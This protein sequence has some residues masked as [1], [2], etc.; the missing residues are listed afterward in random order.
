M[1]LLLC[2]LEKKLK[3]EKGQKE[4]RGTE[5]EREEGERVRILKLEERERNHARGAAR[6]GRGRVGLMI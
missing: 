2:G 4:K 3:K 6:V 5:K 1:L